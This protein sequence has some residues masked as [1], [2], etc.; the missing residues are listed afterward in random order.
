[1]LPVK[2]EN[3]DMSHCLR[4][5][6]T[7]GVIGK[8]IDK[9]LSLNLTGEKGAGKK[10]LLED[11]RAC[12]LPDT[13]ILLIDLKGYTANYDGLLREIH[14]QLTLSG[15]VPGRLSEL[16]EGM[17]KEPGHVLALLANYDALLDNARIDSQYDKDF[18]DDLNFIKNKN[19]V[20]LLCTSERP[21]NSSLVFIAGEAFDNSWLTVEIIDLP[22][23]TRRQILAELERRLDEYNWLYLKTN[24]DDKEKIVEHIRT[25]P[26]PNTLLSFL[27][28]RF[29]AQTD[30]EMQQPFKKRFNHWLKAFKKRHKKNFK[31]RVYNARGEVV[32]LRNAA[33][34]KEF[35]IPV[36]GKLINALMSW[37]QKK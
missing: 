1:M 27:A 30:E 3:V 16:F 6:F 31:K 34:V 9:R 7:G 11:I 4:P 32:K 12:K 29:S 28:E 14:S 17:E 20:S 2:L 13:K 22:E 36:F 18:I 25:L 24:Y 5:E 19:N 8:L 21:H 23:L 33:G 26:L 10:R 37:L 15:D 35:R